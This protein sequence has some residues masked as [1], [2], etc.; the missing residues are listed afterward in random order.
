MQS[1]IPGDHNAD[2]TRHTS[3]KIDNLIADAVAARLQVVGPELKDLLRYS[4][5]RLFPARLLLIY[6]AA[7]VGAKRMGKPIDLNFA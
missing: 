1:L 5:K 7:V 3:G 2:V 6:G 4:G